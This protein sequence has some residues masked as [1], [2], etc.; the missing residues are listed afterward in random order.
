MTPLDRYFAILICTLL[1]LP[2]CAAT[3][4]VSSTLDTGGPCTTQCTLRQAITSANATAAADSINFGI[5]LS[6]ELLIQPVTPL[7]TITQ[8]VTIN[9]YAQRG[10]SVNTDPVASNAVLRIRLDGALQGGAGRGLAV[11]ASDVTIKGLS[12][13]RFSDSGIR[14]GSDNGGVLCANPPSNGFIFGNFVGLAPDGQAGAGNFR[15]IIVNSLTRIGSTAPEDRNVISGSQDEGVFLS[16]NRA[17][18]SSVIGNLIGTDKT[19]TLNRGNEGSGIITG[20]QVA[21]TALGSTAAPNLIAYNGSGIVVREGINHRLNFNRFVA[22]SGLAID[23][24]TPGLGSGVSLNDNLDADAGGNGQQNYLDDGFNV[25]RTAGGLQING[26]LRRIATTTIAFTITAYASRNCDSSGHGQGELLL[27]TATSTA[28]SGAPVTGATPVNVTI[29]VTAQPPFGSFITTTVTSP[30]GS[31]S[32]FSSCTQLEQPLVVNS[33]N[34]VADGACS[35]AHCSLRDAI[36]AANSTPAPDAITFNITTPATGEL[37]IQPSTALPTITAPVLIDGYSQPGALVNTDQNVS[38]AELRVRIDGDLQADATAS[39]LAI[40]ASDVTVR[41]LIITG[42]DGV[43]QRALRA[44]SPNCSLALEGIQI[45]GNFFGLRNDGSVSAN[46]AIVIRDENITFGGAQVADRNVVAGSLLDGVSVTSGDGSAGN[47]RVINN[48]F[49]TDKT[50]LL[51]RGNASAG[52]RISGSKV[53]VGSLNAPNLFAFNG[54]G[55]I[56]NNIAN[57]LENDFAANRLANNTGIAIDLGDNALPTP[58]DVDDIDTGPNGLQNFPELSRAERFEGGILINGTLDVPAGA[59]PVD[60]RIGVYASSG[61]DASG[62]GEGERL[63]GVATVSLQGSAEDF[64]FALN[65]LDALEPGV[66][67]TTTATGP[68]GT[69]EFSQCLAA[70][71]GQP[72]IAVDS[73]LDIGLTALGCELTGDANECTLREAM[74]LANSNIDASLIRFAIATNGPHSIL[75][76][77]LLPAITAPLTIDGYTQPGAAENA[78]SVGS[79]ATLAIQLR[80]GT[81]TVAFGLMVCASD[82]SIRGLSITQFSIANI[83]TQANATLDCT[84]QGNNVRIAGNFIGLLANGVATSNNIG[85]QISNTKVVL[86]GPALADRNIIASNNQQGVRLGGV[87]SNSSLIQNN[88]IGAG[89]SPSDNRGN[90]GAGI[91]IKNGSNIVVGGSGMLANTLRFNGHGIVLTAGTGNALAANDFAS[92]IGLGID[93]SSGAAADGVTPNDIDDV[94]SGPNNKQ[95]FPVLSS[96]SATENSLSVTGTLDVPSDANSAPYRITLYESTSCNASGFGEGNL[97][98][99]EVSVNFSAAAENFLITLKLPP[100]SAASVVTATATDALGNTSEFSACIA[101]PLLDAVFADG[102]EN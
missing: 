10:T 35:A 41:G 43:N 101:A 60:Y 5:R 57:V 42:F 79:D 52:L 4:I 77:S 70:T 81:G 38:N 22:N 32:E 66:Q 39:G 102:F 50:G 16:G 24:L 92:N 29:P 34:D 90:N 36:I 96:A 98:L 23:L 25:L 85:V 51:N 20:F 68:E 2:L 82:V 80:K 86:G 6:G 87:G 84:V 63:L 11:C 72:G 53:V 54:R 95:N 1:P 75:V 47:T 13:T 83:A 56:V 78:A 55:I 88:L 33:R 73:V 9:G 100:N 14:F 8:P 59:G 64:S 44:G 15:A 7:P 31:T 62:F 69:S 93:L 67:I 27:G 17:S 21:T 19:A 46:R 12:V 94:D 28:S 49:G 76:D 74:T 26:T 3:I 89:I 58:N 48:L 91:E 30:G 18:G 37:L 45:A 97:R 65:S 61:C 71:D 40:C 99:G